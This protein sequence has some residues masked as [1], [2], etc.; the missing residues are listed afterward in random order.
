[1]TQYLHNS[2]ISEKERELDSQERMIVNKTD[3]TVLNALVENQ[4]ATRMELCETT[5]L[6]RTTI[7]DALT[8]L[9]LKKMVVKY[10]RPSKTRGRPKV[11]Y[12]VI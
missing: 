3:I 11:F 2:L 5:G 10:S 1:M 6:P 8:R 12:R 4:P 9:I 7:Y